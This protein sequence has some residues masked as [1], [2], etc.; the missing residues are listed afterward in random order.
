MQPTSVQPTS[1][2]PTSVKENP[3]SHL[4]E[5]GSK[6]RGSWLVSSINIV[7]NFINCGTLFGTIIRI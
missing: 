1:E 4:S 7:I 3:C 6:G 5:Q 2:Q